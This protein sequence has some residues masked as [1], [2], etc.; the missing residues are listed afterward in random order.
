MNTS[1]RRS[2]ASSTSS[3][4]G[5]GSEHA[6]RRHFLSSSSVIS[7]TMPFP[8][9]VRSRRLSCMMTRWRSFVKRMSVSKPRMPFARHHLKPPAALSSYS[10][11]L[12]RWAWM[13]GVAAEAA[14]KQSASA[15][16]IARRARNRESTVFMGLVLYQ[17]S[18]E[19]TAP[20]PSD[21]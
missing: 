11:R 8:S 2:K 19:P 12:P 4:V 13:S 16:E 15:A 6:C 17:K 9:V 1:P 14:A 3:S 7:S 18:E 21:G 10:P 20:R 5:T